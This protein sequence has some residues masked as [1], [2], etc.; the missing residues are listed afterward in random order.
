MNGKRFP[1]LQVLDGRQLL[2]WMVFWRLGFV[3]C[4]WRFLIFTLV[5]FVDYRT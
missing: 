5:G 3:L 2:R 1:A 4:R